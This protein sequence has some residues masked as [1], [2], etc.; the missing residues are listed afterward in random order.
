DAAPSG[1]ERV[2]VAADSG[3]GVS[4][5]IDPFAYT[6]INP[7]LTVTLH[8]RPRGEWI[9]LAARTEFDES[10][11]GLADARLYDSGGPVGRGVQT[12]LIRKRG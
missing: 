7:D 1:L 8:H 4:V 10:G 2:L 3:N 6:F 11:V 5:R 12:L 9:G